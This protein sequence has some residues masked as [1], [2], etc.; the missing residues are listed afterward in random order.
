MFC[1]AIR[2]F[3]QFLPFWN[4]YQVE[5]FVCLLN[6]IE[7]WA[8]L[9]CKNFFYV[10]QVNYFF[11]YILQNFQ[12]LFRN[13]MV[14]WCFVLYIAWNKFI[15]YWILLQYSKLCLYYT[16]GLFLIIIIMFKIIFGINVLKYLY[17]I[18]H[19]WNFL[20]N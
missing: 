6:Y 2:K 20:F 13:G 12:H 16:D 19:S 11:F 15:R 9:G 14:S 7:V 4:L 5:P 1:W 10:F 17:N 18:F 8:W 3:M